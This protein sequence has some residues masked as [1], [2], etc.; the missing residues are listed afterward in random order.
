MKQARVFIAC[1]RLQSEVE[2]AR[3]REHLTAPLSVLVK[4]VPRSIPAS[5]S[6][7]VRG[8]RRTGRCTGSTH[9]VNILLVISEIS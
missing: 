6:A 9:G 3:S 7:G 5:V 4:N 8:T 2:P 1:N